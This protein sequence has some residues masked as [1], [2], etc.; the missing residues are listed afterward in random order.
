MN[1]FRLVITAFSII[2][3]YEATHQLVAQTTCSKIASSL[4]MNRSAKSVH[5]GVRLIRGSIVYS[6]SSERP[7]ADDVE[8]EKL[9]IFQRFF[10]LPLYVE[11][12]ESGQYEKAYQIDVDENGKILVIPLHPADT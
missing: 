6:S 11:I 5:C 8:S 9:N 3:A 7:N 4:I 12:G 10:A 2:G 1:T